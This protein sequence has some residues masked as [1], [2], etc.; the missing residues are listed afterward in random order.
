MPVSEFQVFKVEL[1][2]KYKEA[3]ANLYRVFADNFPEQVAL[4]QD[5]AK[6]KSKQAMFVLSQLQKVKNG[7][8]ELNPERLQIEGIRASLNF[9]SGQAQQ[10]LQKA[11]TLKAALSLAVST[12]ESIIEKRWFEVFLKPPADFTTN[13]KELQDSTRPL[14]NQLKNLLFKFR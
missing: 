2:A 9:I 14:I 4:W 3:I 6:E 12:E 7:Q 11:L 13:L 10:A 8:G 5:L 1:L